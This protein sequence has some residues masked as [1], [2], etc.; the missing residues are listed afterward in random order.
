M[1][2]RIIVEK[3]GDLESKHGIEINANAF[4]EYDEYNDQ[5]RANIIG[6]VFGEIDYDIK[7]ILSAYNSNGE[8]IG[9]DY[10]SIEEDTFEGIQPFSETIFPPDGELISK[11]RIYPQ[12]Y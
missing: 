8:I 12:K 4:L 10:T 5:F 6:E 2:D 7:I 1:A 9:T 3:L 11:V